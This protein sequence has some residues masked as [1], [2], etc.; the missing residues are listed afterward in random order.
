MKGIY[1]MSGRATSEATR[2]ATSSPGSGSGPSRSAG[3]ASGTASACGRGRVPVN[4][5]P[6]QALALGL[7]TS[8]TF[9]RTGSISSASARL[10]SSMENRLRARMGSVGSTLY[11]LTWKGRDTPSGQTIFARRA[12]TPR[13]SGKGS[14]SS[15]KGWVSPTARDHSRGGKDPRPHDT[16]IPLS[17]E[18]ALSGWN[19]PRGTDGS[20]GGPNQANGAL[21]PDAAKAGWP[22]PAQRDFRSESATDEFN[23]KRW[24]H[25]RGK[26]ASAVATLAGWATPQANQANDTPERF[27]ERKR[28]T[29][30]ARITVTGEMLTGSSAG[31][32]NGGQLNPEHS[33][34]LMGI[35]KE[36]DACAPTE[37]RSSR[38]SRRRS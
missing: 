32:E 20:N 25:A 29:G 21:Y 35:P 15:V 27:L 23:E 17:Q 37:T 30:P 2:N 1:G 34:W 28:E 38:K 19:T 26:P 4:L 22:T 9:G 24:D 31:M 16:G 6:R 12:S 7:L 5:S 18:A 36:W 10:R 8:G 3:R 33:R 11:R 14:G 13:T